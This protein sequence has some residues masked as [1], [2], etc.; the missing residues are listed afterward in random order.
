[1]RNAALTVAVGLLLLVGLFWL[2][3]P[4][5]ASTPV[6]EAPPALT[7][8]IA[9]AAA[10]APAPAAENNPVV[11]PAPQK[12]ELQIA[13]G[14][15]VAEARSYS[16]RQGEE[17]ELQLLS[18]RAGEL[19]LHGYDLEAKVQAD[20]PALLRFRADHAGRFEMEL[21]SKAGHVELG[22]LEV[23]PR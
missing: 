22:A 14:K 23:Q 19:H 2:L 7:A 3:K 11:E 5:S 10:A 15:L 4:D 1:M 20:Q 13:G 21:H 6:S 8:Q 16:L 12:L 9:E 18:D 17:V